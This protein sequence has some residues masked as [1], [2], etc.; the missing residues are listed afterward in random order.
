[1]LSISSLVVPSA[2]LVL[3]ILR[4]VALHHFLRVKALAISLLVSIM[5]TWLL[6]EPIVVLI[7]VK[8]TPLVHFLIL[9]PFIVIELPISASHILQL[10]LELILRVVCKHTLVRLD[11]LIL[12]LLLRMEERIILTILVPLEALIISH[13][14]L[15]WVK[16]RL[17]ILEILGWLE[18]PVLL[19]ASVELF[20]LLERLARLE[21]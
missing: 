13:P 2:I 8:T 6:L 7:C 1:M 4:L 20:W 3:V 12:M 9:V 14:V 11:I 21:A 19:H 5:A 17:L 15:L 16:V 18:G 10:G